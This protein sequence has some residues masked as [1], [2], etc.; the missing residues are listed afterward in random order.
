MPKN[1]KDG[2]SVTILT[3]L[4]TT[5]IL[6]VLGWT[7]TGTLKAYSTEIDVGYVKEQ[8]ETMNETLSEILIVSHEKQI[9]SGN[10]EV[11]IKNCEDK[12]KRC[13]SIMER[14]FQ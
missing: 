5:L 4:S 8:M 13:E 10:H 1:I 2:F 6:A 7:G 14:R 12:A 11:R 9:V 3:M